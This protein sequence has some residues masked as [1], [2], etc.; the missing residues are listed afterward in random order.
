MA[1]IGPYSSFC[2]QVEIPIM[3][4]AP[5]GPLASGQPDRHAP[6]ADPRR[7]ARASAASRGRAG[8]L[9]PDGRAELRPGHG[10]RGPPGRGGRHAR[11]GAR[12]EAGLR[13]PRPRGVETW[14]KS[15]RSGGPPAGSGSE[16]PAQRGSAPS[17]RARAR[18]RTGRALRRPGRLHRRL[19]VRGRGRV[20]KALRARLGDRVKIMTRRS[21]RPGPGPVE[22]AGPARAGSVHELHGRPAHRARA[23]PGGTALRA[24]LRDTRR[25]VGVLP[26]AQATDSCSTR[27]PAPTGRAPR[28]SRSC[29]A[30]RSG[31][32]SSATSASTGTGTSRPP[33]SRSS[34]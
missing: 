14:S 27:S 2:G 34:A 4:R 7:H 33:S 25:P 31:T 11:R 32:A 20:L 16:S 15:A 26:A 1:V 8:G 24:R 22:V 5:G 17:P 18:S 28:C 30:P 6:R 12:T 23:E 21:V 10:A 3:N 13:A 9:L 19:R 29:A